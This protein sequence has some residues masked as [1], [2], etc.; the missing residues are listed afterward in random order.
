MQIKRLI[1]YFFFLLPTLLFSQKKDINLCA[2]I[3]IVNPRFIYEDRPDVTIIRKPTNYTIGNYL[4]FRTNYKKYY[5]T[6]G[7]MRVSQKFQEINTLANKQPDWV[8]HKASFLN[9]C[10]FYNASLGAEIFNK[11]KISLVYYTG[12]VFARVS[13]T[14]YS[15][16]TIKMESFD[17]VY[18]GTS[19]GTSHY[20]R[21]NLAVNYQLNRSLGLGFNLSLDNAI[22]PFTENRRLNRYVK[23][24]TSMVGIG[25]LLR[26]HF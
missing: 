8:L 10:N 24:S 7:Y 15:A 4:E 13:R 11:K 3:G 9:K 16:R 20:I 1:T 6:M 21:N 2:S 14:T 18:S 23:P 17:T 5:L 19:L 12:F 25:I 22:K 26:Y